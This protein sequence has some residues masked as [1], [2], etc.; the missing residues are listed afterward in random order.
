LVTWSSTR[1]P[2]TAPWCGDTAF[3]ADVTTTAD[4]GGGGVGET[5]DVEP[6][7]GAPRY[8]QPDRDDAERFLD[9]WLTAF[10]R[11]GI[12]ELERLATTIGRWRNSASWSSPGFARSG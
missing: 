8:R 5:H 4:V 2:A 3:A 10:A 7:R 12:A 1:S 11:C 6:I 9:A